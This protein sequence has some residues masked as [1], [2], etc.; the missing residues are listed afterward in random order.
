[1]GAVDRLLD[2]L[3][4]ALTAIPALLIALTL[5]AVWQGTLASVAAAVAL[6]ATPEATRLVRS[7]VRALRDEP[8]VEAARALGTPIWRVMWRRLSWRAAT[9]LVVCGLRIA[10]AAVLAEAGLSFL[11]VGLTPDIASWGQVMGEGRAHFQAAAYRIFFPALFLTVALLALE[12]LAAGLSAWLGR[13]PAQ[14]T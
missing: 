10:A 4:D 14:P 12:L 9:P 6:A 3:L 7:R 11:G 8:F 2:P 13:A 5:V 1:M